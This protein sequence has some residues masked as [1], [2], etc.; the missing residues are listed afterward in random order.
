MAAAW[1]AWR[2]L[3][4]SVGLLCKSTRALGTCR[5]GGGLCYGGWLLSRPPCLPAAGPHWGL[6]E[7]AHGPAGEGDSG[8]GALQLLEHL[9][10]VADGQQARED[11][12]LRAE[13]A[14]LGVSRCQHW[15]GLHSTAA[16]W[17]HASP[18]ATVGV[19]GGWT[20]ANQPA[21]IVYRW[22]WPNGWG[23][24]KIK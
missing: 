8:G 5:P 13:R 14:Y 17:R 4:G 9:L 22:D 23:N 10:Q 6:Q 21:S 24:D 18:W 16:V 15:A 1:A 3:N 20:W 12:E 11:E 7:V 2:R 19:G